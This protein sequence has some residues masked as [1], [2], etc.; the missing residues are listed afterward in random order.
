MERAQG[1]SREA[2]LQRRI[3]QLE[4]ENGTLRRDLSKALETGSSGANSS[5]RD[6]ASPRFYEG[7]CPALRRPHLLL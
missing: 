1:W 6:G 7:A 4:A 3:A 2:Q 5:P